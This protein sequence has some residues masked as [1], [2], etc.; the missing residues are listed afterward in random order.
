LPA[1]GYLVPQQLLQAWGNQAFWQQDF[2]DLLSSPGFQEGT[3]DMGEPSL[4]A[5][6][7]LEPDC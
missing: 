6:G 1:L 7:I 4:C 2:W 5:A 3:E